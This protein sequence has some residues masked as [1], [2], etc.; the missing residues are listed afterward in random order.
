MLTSF[1]TCCC[2]CQVDFLYGNTI[3][4]WPKGGHVLRSKA[5]Q[6][7]PVNGGSLRG[8]FS[9]TQVVLGLYD[10]GQRE[11]R[12]V[13]G[14]IAVFGDSSFIDMSTYAFT[15][16]GKYES[17]AGKRE[18]LEMLMAFVNGGI[19]PMVQNG[20][21][22]LKHDSFADKRLMRALSATETVD[23]SVLKKEETLRNA[24]HSR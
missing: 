11:E 20:V 22:E 4:S 17:S 21:E 23:I 9:P 13:S 7:S 5:G 15:D 19:L 14:R 3:S 2:C 8:Q 24:E 12:G 6:L 16:E 18:L 10:V 1:T